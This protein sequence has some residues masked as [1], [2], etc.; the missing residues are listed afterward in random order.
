MARQRKT[1][2]EKIISDNRNTSREERQAEM[3]D[4]AA[5]QIGARDE[6]WHDVGASG[7][8]AFQNSWVNY[9]APY[10]N[11]RFKKINGV[12]W[13]EMAVKSGLTGAAVFTL[14]AGY[15]P[16][17]TVGGVWLWE[18]NGDTLINVTIAANGVVAIVSS[19]GNAL[20][21]GTFAFPAD[22]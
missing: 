7:E 15:R 6:A 20:S 5:M 1:F 18:A 14:P 17:G 13:V 8:P 4:R 12:V 21:F 10:P 11:T 22:Q 2:D 19:S 9:G 16:S 3:Q